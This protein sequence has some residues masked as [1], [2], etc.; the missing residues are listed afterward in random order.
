MFKHTN[1]ENLPVFVTSVLMF[2][3][4]LPTKCKAKFIK[5]YGAAA[6]GSDA[7]AAA[8]AASSPRHDCDVKVSV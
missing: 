2:L 6:A 8:R 3:V 5:P 7:F 4:S 1:E